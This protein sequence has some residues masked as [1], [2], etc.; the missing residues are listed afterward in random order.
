M[1]PAQDD[2]ATLLET[3]SCCDGKG[4]S[5]PPLP[6]QGEVGVAY[7]CP[8]H[9]EVQQWWPGACPVCGMALEPEQPDNRSDRNELLDMQR[10]FVV[11]AAFSLPLMAVAMGEHFGIAGPGWVQALLAA[12]VVSWGA[13]PFW[14][15]AAVSLRRG[16]ANMFTL[17]ALGVAAATFYSVWLLMQGSAHVYFESAAMIVTFVLLGQVLELQAREHAGD[18]MRALLN[19]APKTGRVI[20]EE[21]G[22]EFD[23]PLAGIKAG[24]LLRVRPGESVPV[25]GVVVEGESAV[26]QS[27]VT[28]ESMPVAKAAGDK[29]I[30]GTMNMQ[31]SF[32]MRAEAVGKATVLARIVALV[33]ATARSKA[34][35]QGLADRVA[36]YFVPGVIAVAAL[37]GLGWGLHGGIGEGIA[38]AVAVVV[39]AC[40]CALG[41]AT[42]MAMLCGSGRGARAGVLVRHAAAMQQM[43]AIDTLVLDKTGT[44]TEGAPKLLMVMPTEGH[45]E[46]NLLRMAASL[47]QHSEHPLSK[48]I[49]Q[50]AKDRGLG[51]L[52]VHAFRAIPGKGLSAIADGRS[53]S[54]GSE[55]YLAAQNIPVTLKTK[56][57]PYMSQGQTVVFV[58]MDHH[59]I[60]LLMLADPA[61]K[62]APEV[63]K[64]LK[65][66]G[67]ELVMMTGDSATTAVAVGRKLGIEQVEADVSPERKAELIKALQAAGKK[68][69]MAGDG[70]ND[71]PALAQADLGIAMGNGTDVAME[72][73]AIVLMSGDLSGLLRARRLSKG[74]MQ[75][76]RQNLVLAFAY[77]ILAVPLAA[78]LFGFSLNPMVAS[79]AMAASSLSV[80]ANSLRLRKLAL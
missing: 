4:D 68:V 61:K 69:A 24:N 36:A 53:V 40:P 46:P 14:Q 72:S 49:V 3:Q 79:A 76:V 25:D 38:R 1:Q 20:D 17:I 18:D 2:T 19:L 51:L 31:G 28:G 48:A 22:S 55:A 33:A 26:D 57:K 34:P 45:S 74:V 30:G 75:V 63:L 35:V 73:A 43:E 64:A 78:G 29:V 32:V 8:M 12:P 77:N 50:A 15:R 27:M 58:A 47:E 67:I 70:I 23:L 66:D 21:D 10:R 7:R 80:M 6:P 16:R 13:W 41:L 65:A 39:I 5:P 71:A 54:M 11:S 59:C 62:E 9:P 52:K 56:A 44:L 42:P 37:T 60:G